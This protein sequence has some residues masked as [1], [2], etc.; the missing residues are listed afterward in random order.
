MFPYIQ[1]KIYIYSGKL[2]KITLSYMYWL[3]ASKKGTLSDRFIGEQ[4][5][6]FSYDDEKIT[7]PT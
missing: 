4:T 3:N 7:L 1:V 6:I 2:T 5:Y